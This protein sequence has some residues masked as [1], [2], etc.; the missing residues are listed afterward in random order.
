MARGVLVVNAIVLLLLSVGVGQFV[1]FSEDM[2]A[3]KWSPL[4]F[5]LKL[6]GELKVCPVATTALSQSKKV[7]CLLR[8]PLSIGGMAALLCLLTALILL[9]ISTQRTSI[10]NSTVETI[11]HFFLKYYR[12]YVGRKMLLNF[13]DSCK[14]PRLQQETLLQ[15]IIRKNKSTA[16]GCQFHLGCIKSL[17]DF[18][19]KHPITEYSRYEP[20]V[21]RIAG[22]EENIMT[23][24][25]VRRLIL[26]SGTTGRSKMIPQDEY[27]VEKTFILKEALLH[28][29]YPQ[30]HPMQSKLR[31]HCNSQ[32]RKSGGGISM[33]AATAL[34]DYMT[35]DM[36]IYSSPSAAFM[37]GTE[38]EASYIHLLFALRDKN[39]G[40][41]WVTFI[42]LFVD[43]MKFLESNWRKIVDDLSEGTLNPDLKL[44]SDIRKYL[45]RALGSGDPI[46]A[47]EVRRELEKGFDG[48]IKRL[49]PN[50]V[51]ISTIDNVGLRQRVKKTYAKGVEMYS[52]VYISSENLLGLNLWPYNEGDAEYVLHLSENVFEF[53]HENDIDKSNP[54]TFLVDE[55][56]VGEKYEVVFTQMYGLYRYRLGDVVE[57]T[58]FYQNC[59]KVKV[60][61]RKA[62]LVNL[63]GEKIDQTVIADSIKA[64][65]S[66]W[67]DSV[68]LSNY[69]V[70]ESALLTGLYK[71][72][73]E[74]EQ[75]TLLSLKKNK[76]LIIKPAD[77]GG[78]TVVWRRDLYV[79]EAEK[80]LSGQTAYTK[81]PMDPTS[82]IQTF[83]KKTLATLVSKKHLPE[84]AKALLH[85]CPQISNFYL[86]PKIH[87]ANN[88]G[89]PIVSSHSCPTVL[90]SQYV[91]SVLSP[92]VSTLPSFIQDTSHFLRISP[93][94]NCFQ[95]NGRFFRQIKGAAMG[96]K[97]GPSVACLTMG[98]FE[99]Q[100]FSRYT[101]I[102]PILYKGNVE[103]LCHDPSTRD[104]FPE[105]PITAFRIEK[106][107]SKHLVRASQPQAVVPNT[108]GT[109]P[110]NR[111]RCNTC[112]VVS[113]DKN[114][115][116]VG[117]NNNRLNVH[118][119]FTCTSA[120]V[121]Y[122]LECKRC[123]ILYVGETK[124]RLADRVTEHLRSIKQNLPGFPV[125]THFNPPS[126]CS[127]R[128]LMVS[129]AISCRGSD[130]DRLAAEN[131]LI[132]KLGTL[133][134][135][136]L[137][138]IDKNIYER[139]EFYRIYRDT[140]QIS[141]PIVYIVEKGGFLNLQEFML[142]NSSTARA[143]FKM[144]L[145]LRTREMG[146]ILLKHLKM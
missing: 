135:H 60:L 69:C 53:I 98:H 33:A 59:P 19:Q 50:L 18:S 141:I 47:T 91:D 32:L 104:H 122:V 62:T 120:N 87:K 58:G 29:V 61:Y 84:S 52:P 106:N 65:L 46:R 92:L 44:C 10:H 85:P 54:K 5:A 137:N 66:K 7:T 125:A 76:N 82:E 43:V 63:V 2:T 138:E 115:S 30:L 78:A 57:I 79:S 67:D 117:P 39:V 16:Y 132:M 116:I 23:T 112:P 119:H 64:S 89:R 143:Q 13:R 49:W 20:F 146:E 129:A 31:Y 123:N 107:I 17:E 75:K 109:F 105:P 113:C 15:E 95:F 77:K 34:E 103:T 72:N 80:Q 111:G 27:Y 134:P 118:Q 21:N 4:C 83:V 139:H 26:T 24:E 35:R 14:N 68:E 70:S 114:L 126:T 136:G 42:S 110:C 3:I 88:P 48:I 101:G 121:V 73:R 131:R 41:V 74:D 71:D 12:L 90:I 100:M 93:H 140:K 145:K 102:K 56:E 81:L 22:G 38:Y 45:I 96:T 97:L 130:H 25:K 144:P 133:S 28:D 37:I 128:Y 36:M 142:A 55:V 124:R 51:V 99:E 108:P 6:L 8:T 86:L 40:S 9:F 127:I 1:F 11:R 94:T